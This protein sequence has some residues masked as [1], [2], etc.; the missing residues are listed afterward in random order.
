MAIFCKTK[1]NRKRLGLMKYD[2][3]CSPKSYGGQYVLNLHHHVLTRKASL[4][5]TLLELEQPWTIMMNALM[6]STLSPATY[7]YWHLSVG[8]WHFSVG[9]WHLSQWELVGRFESH[10]P[11]SWTCQRL[12][13]YNVQQFHGK[14]DCLPL[15]APCSSRVFIGLQCWI[16]HWPFW[17]LV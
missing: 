6:A 2:L 8:Y 9:Y 15:V 4:I 3:V 17:G 13:T 10:T 5:P 11:G 16:C 12:E 1:P 7:G 14:E